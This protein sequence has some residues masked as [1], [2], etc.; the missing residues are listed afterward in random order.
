MKVQSE[1]YLDNDITTESKVT[2]VRNTYYLPTI[3]KKS[4]TEKCEIEVKFKDGSVIKR[5]FTLHPAENACVIN[6][7]STF[8]EKRNTG[9]YLCWTTPWCR[10]RLRKYGIYI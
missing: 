5:D 8:G 4:K 3:Y 10:C 1:E 9:N 2:K 6:Y 7:A